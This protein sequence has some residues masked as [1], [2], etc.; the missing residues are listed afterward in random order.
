MLSRTWGLPLLGTVEM[1]QM[2]ASGP[3]HS[4]VDCAVCWEWAPIA[5][6]GTSG[7]GQ[8]GLDRSH[9]AGMFDLGLNTCLYFMSE[10]NLFVL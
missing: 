6:S 9:V 10:L 8:A 2:E 7:Q 3:L 1:P 5:I 4:A